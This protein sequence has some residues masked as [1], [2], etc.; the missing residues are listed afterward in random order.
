MDLEMSSSE[1][2]LILKK[3]KANK[4]IG[5]EKDDPAISEALKLGDRLAKWIALVNTL[6]SPESAIRLTS[7]ATRR[8]IPIEKP[9]MYSPEIIKQETRRILSELP[10]EIKNVLISNENLPNHISIDDETFILYA[11]RIDRN[12]QSA[13]RYKS[14][15]KFRSHYIEAG[16]RDVRGY[17]YLHKNEITENELRNAQTI[18]ADKVNPIKEALILI[19]FNTEDDQG[20]CQDRVHSAFKNNS[21]S[22]I[23]EK[24]FIRSKKIWNDF[25]KI[26]NYAKRSDIRWSSTKT[27]VPFNNPGIPK[28][29]PYLRDNIEDEFRWNDWALKIS[30]GRYPG[31]PT[32]KFEPGVVPHVNGLGGN[33]IVM[34]A[35]QPIEEYESQWTIR[36]EF[37]HVLGLPDCY[38]EFYD[39]EANAYVNYQLDTSD[40]MCSRAGNMKERIFSELEKAYAK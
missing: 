39:T 11:R 14:V 36:H 28:F 34:D 8:G 25:F 37:G 38:H 27:V 13:A 33:E 4:I 10:L 23:Y 35:N 21:L 29:G 6:R 15:D 22:L 9:N 16:S 20:L 26:P 2:R 32:L 12:Y 30:F 7:S 19:C 40:L 5:N 1:Y 24:Y 31:G 17:Y 3:L 18:P